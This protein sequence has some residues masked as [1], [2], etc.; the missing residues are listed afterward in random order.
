VTYQVLARAWRPQSFDDVMGQDAVV[1]TL[2][3][4]LTGDTLGHAYLFSGL[5]GVGKTTV[6]RLL[7]KAVNCE[8]G[9]TPD[10]CGKCQACS[11]IVGGACLDVVEL[12][13]ASN[14]GIDDVRELR[15]LL[16]Y[17]PTRDRCRVIIIDEV[18]MLTREA[19]NALLKSLEE[20]PPYILF[21]FAT[22]ERHKVPGTILSRCQ[23]LEFRPV[24]T[25]LIRDH[26]QVIA[27]KE[28]FSVTPQASAM[29]ARAAEGS[30]RDA[31]SLIDQLRAFSGDEVDE[32]AVSA[33]LGVPPFEQVA[34]L[35]K[36][37]ATGMTA[38]A[39]VLLRQ[40]LVAGHDCTVLFKETGRMLRTL[41]HISLDPALEP[42]LTD[43]HTKLLAAIAEPLGSDAL[44]R[45]LGLWL[46]QEPLLRDSGNRE[47]ALEV[48]CLRLAR[49]PAVQQL[50]ALLTGDTE[51]AVST[52]NRSPADPSLPPAAAAGSAPTP[53]STGGT[54]GS[55][56]APGSAA[57]RL[58]N[59]LWDGNHRRLS[60]AVE[61]AELVVNASVLELRFSAAQE[62]LARFSESAEVRPVLDATCRQILPEVSEIRITVKD[63][64]QATEPAAALT[65][66]A[67]N[68]PEVAMVQQVFGGEIKHVWPDQEHR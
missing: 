45:M 48:A 42:A 34:Q 9:P 41:L 15:E 24:A 23:Q 27:G 54:N 16:R 14:R 67:L 38:E 2:R 58:S 47:L 37:L 30:V 13:G 51:V 25:D 62:A 61:S 6:A 43:D 19:F 26:L 7:A 35:I 56:A 33:V 44:A 59:A 52:G 63:R 31:L 21:I 17:R 18:H 36:K 29:I 49:W 55:S 3:N 5:R 39:L 12:D 65:E 50:E 22:T 10:P 28:G 11:D 32:E 46:D 40:E 68:D 64:D 4:A 20:P 60:G 57:E 53:T 8:Q 1:R 66:K